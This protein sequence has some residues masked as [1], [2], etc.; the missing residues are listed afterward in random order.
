VQAPPRLRGSVVLRFVALLLG[1]FLFA[2]GIVAYLESKLG[3]SPWDVLHQGLANHTPLSFGEANI[4]VGLFATAVAWMLG[5]RIGLA[6]IANAALVGTF[7]DRLTA[8]GAVRGLA[9]ESLGVH[10]ALLAAGVVAIGLG[11]GLYLGAAFGAGPRD[12]LM[13]VGAKRLSIR[14]AVVRGAIEICAL[15][16]GI[17]LGG[18]V[19]VGTIVFALAVGPSIEAAFWLLDRV[20]LTLAEPAPAAAPAVA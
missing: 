7:V 5:A 13:V 15:V 12:S 3:L 16:A 17:A 18:T 8:V 4:V 10:I 2:V 19:G 9:H 6:T 1:L 14:I 11:S 20:R